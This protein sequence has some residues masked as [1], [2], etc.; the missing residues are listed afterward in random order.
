MVLNCRCNAEAIKLY[1]GR[2]RAP[3]NLNF[4]KS[5]S[6]GSILSKEMYFS[7]FFCYTLHIV[8]VVALPLVRGV[9]RGRSR[10]EVRVCTVIS[11]NKLFYE[12]VK[13]NE[14]FCFEQSLQ[15]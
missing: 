5:L 1:C 7:K 6:V 4:P 9:W 11:M 3:K 13:M 8:S 14:Y 2:L 15:N 12:S 10:E